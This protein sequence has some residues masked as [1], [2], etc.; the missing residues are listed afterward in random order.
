MRILVIEDEVLLASS[1]KEILSTA[2]ATGP[3]GKRACIW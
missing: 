3:T 1:I 2:K